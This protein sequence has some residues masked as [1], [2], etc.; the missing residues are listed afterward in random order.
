MAE[1][2]SKAANGKYRAGWTEVFG[3]Q[4]EVQKKHFKAMMDEIR[5]PTGVELHECRICRILSQD[6]GLCPICKGMNHG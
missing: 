5:K 4:K 3:H 2:R 6:M 1:I